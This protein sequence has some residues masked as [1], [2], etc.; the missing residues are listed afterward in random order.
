L[1]LI[2]TA[3]KLLLS[4]TVLVL[5]VRSPTHLALIWLSKYLSFHPFD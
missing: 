5:H 2:S 4:V 1:Q 3:D